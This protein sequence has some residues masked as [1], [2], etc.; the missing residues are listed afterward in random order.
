MSRKSWNKPFCDGKWRRWFR[1]KDRNATRSYDLRV[2]RSFLCAYGLELA[3]VCRVI[4]MASIFCHCR[5]AYSDSGSRDSQV[6][7]PET[8]FYLYANKEWLNSHPIPDE[9]IYYGVQTEIQA[10][11]SNDLKDICERA[12]TGPNDSPAAKIIGDFYTSGLDRSQIEDA[13][14]RPL[15]PALKHIAS[16][17][18]ISDI[19]KL[20]GYLQAQRVDAAF[21][22]GCE[23]DRFGGQRDVLCIGQGGFELPER[24]YYLSVDEQFKGIRSSY[25]EH[26][27]RMFKLLGMT[28]S[29]AAE[30]AHV[31][32]RIESALAEAS[33]APVEMR[34]PLDNSHYVTYKE[35][36]SIAPH[37]GWRD[38]F[39]EIGIKSPEIIDV[40]QIKYLRAFDELLGKIPIDEWKTYFR[41]QLLHQYANYLSANVVSEDFD[42]FG[43]TLFGIKREKSQQDRAIDAIN[44]FAGDALGQLY[45]RQYCTPALRRKAWELVNSVKIAFRDRLEKVDWMDETTRLAALEK[46]SKMG[47]KVAYPDCWKDYTTMESDRK[48]FFFNVKAAAECSFKLEMKKVGNLHDDNEWPVTPQ[49]IDAFYNFWANEIVVPAGILR[50]PIFDALADSSINYGA[51]GAIVGHEITHGFD[52][53]G[54]QYDSR[55]AFKDWWS[56]ESAERFSIRALAIVKRFDKYSV[57]GNIQVSGKL[58]LGENIADLGGL[59]TAFGAFERAKN[60]ESEAQVDKV[61]DEQRFFKAYA[62]SLRMNLRPEV[63]RWLAIA[64][65]HAPPEIRVNSTVSNL[66]EF[67][68]AFEIA[69]GSPMWRAPAD[70]TEIW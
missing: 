25:T 12:S 3:R 32:L 37:F 4:C 47:V 64:N 49:T 33:N 67:Y 8:N 66:R 16:V 2:L 53:V 52:D 38:Y 41:W 65:A 34:N 43:K 70:R 24:D 35:L 55:G 1:T 46:L 42:F 7:A 58:T 69:P 30:S 59:A 29:N 17:A 14:L 48:S 68:E 26:I 60:K 28:T 10:V 39:A 6:I 31:V 9:L 54:R 36:Q 56:G 62:N 20:L 50:P 21:S 18:L 45:A 40:C 13:G 5:S 15:T 11:I 57:D 23:K 19:P 61:T 51:L 27:C 63:L 44:A 22:V